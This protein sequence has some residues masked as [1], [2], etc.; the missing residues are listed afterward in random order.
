MRGGILC[1]SQYPAHPF[2]RTTGADDHI[3]GLVVVLV[4]VVQE[5]Q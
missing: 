5:N 3:A 4:F 2:G 1:R